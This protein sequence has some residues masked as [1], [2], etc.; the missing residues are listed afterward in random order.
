[1]NAATGAINSTG[2]AGDITVALGVPRAPVAT[3]SFNTV[4]NLNSDAAVG[5]TFTSSVQTYDSLGTPHVITLTYTKT[6]A[7]AWSFKAEAPGA[8]VTGGVAG[9]PFQ[10]MAGTLAFSAQG[11]LTTVTPTAPA[12]GGGTAPA[13]ADVTFTTPTWKSGAAASALTFDLVDADGVASLTGYKAPS[14]TS[15]ITQNG[16]SAGIISSM[17][18]EADGT[19]MATFGAGQT[20][21]VGQI[22]LASF[23]NPRGLNKLGSNLYGETQA[24]GV[25]NVGTGG[26]G[27]RGS[28]IGSAIEQSNVDIAQEFTSMILA[29]RGYQANSKSITVSDEMLVET[30]NLK[31]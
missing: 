8:E 18:V 17:N 4:T 14:S 15:S 1:V 6:A 20:V 9:T 22:A 24:A 26:T 31:R 2:G 30:L 29:Q 12:A 7:G 25:P 5:E 10:L 28:L 16:S 27:S 21:A 19:I 11:A 3:T 23:N 13:L